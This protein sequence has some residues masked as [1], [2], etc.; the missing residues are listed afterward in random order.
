MNNP[1]GTKG[2]LSENR[3]A[4]TPAF[5]LSPIAAPLRFTGGTGRSGSDLGRGLGWSV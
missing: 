5:A 2:Q 3:R 1:N 4:G